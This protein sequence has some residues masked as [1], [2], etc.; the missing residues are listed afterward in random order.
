M[1][2][3]LQTF[4]SEGDARMLG[5]TGQYVHPRQFQKVPVG[6]N[7]LAVTT[8]YRLLHRML[9]ARLPEQWSVEHPSEDMIC[10]FLE[11]VLA[12]RVRDVQEDLGWGFNEVPRGP[13]NAVKNS[14]EGL[15]LWTNFLS[16]IGHVK[17]DAST[18]LV[19]HIEWERQED[20]RLSRLQEPRHR[21]EIKFWL[22][23]LEQAGIV[24]P[25][26]LLHS[27]KDG[28]QLVMLGFWADDFYVQAIE[29]TMNHNYAYV[30]SFVKSH[31]F[32]ARFEPLV[33]YW[34]G[35]EHL[36]AVREVGANESHY[37][38]ANAPTRP[39]GQPKVHEVAP[40]EHQPPTIP[41]AAE[42]PAV[43]EIHSQVSEA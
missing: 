34:S 6:I 5:L 20:G 31:G 4:L 25:T 27:D 40:P 36:N 28:V 15:N 8:H 38:R 9:D 35:E 17:L 11:D 16:A 26:K 43:S 24:A 18:T 37:K 2:N 23:R 21:D 1:A 30:G 42:S 22:V 3:T 33:R 12:L 19:P 39:S 14:L 32:G 41:S 7:R 10:E 29:D 13:N